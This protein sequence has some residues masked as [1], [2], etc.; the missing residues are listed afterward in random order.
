MIFVCHKLFPC[1][2]GSA[3]EC[4]IR[5]LG[6]PELERRAT[7]P[8]FLRV[9]GAFPRVDPELPH[10]LLRSSSNIYDH[11][12]TLELFLNQL[13]ALSYSRFVF[14]MKR[15]TGTEALLGHLH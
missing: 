2:Y 6:V 1:S 5:E 14:T 4:N 7:M 13:G 10:Q 11:R 3:V 8:A 9:I 12:L 15:V